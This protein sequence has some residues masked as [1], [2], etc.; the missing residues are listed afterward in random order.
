MRITEKQLKKILNRQKKT[1]EILMELKAIG[2][3]VNDRT[4][5]GFV[6]QFNEEFDRHDT[7]IASDSYGYY[8]TT[9][10]KKITKTAMNKFRNGLSQMQNAKKDLQALADKNQLSLMEE[11]ADLFDMMMKMEI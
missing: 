1:E 7:Y 5:R 3:D 4:W 9:N 10:K 8:L 6:R 2:V 11:D